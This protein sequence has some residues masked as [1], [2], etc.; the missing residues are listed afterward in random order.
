M[1][2]YYLSITKFSISVLVFFELSA[3]LVQLMVLVPLSYTLKT[4]L[5]VM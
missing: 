4:S 1:R 5:H 3:Q 2:G